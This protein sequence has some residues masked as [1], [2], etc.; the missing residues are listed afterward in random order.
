MYAQILH[1]QAKNRTPAN[2]VV[3]LEDFDFKE[4]ENI[5]PLTIVQNPNITLYC[6]DPQNQRAIFVETPSD[7]DLSQAPFYYLAQYEHAQR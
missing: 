2:T 5:D 6:I 1:I 7:I 4:G 3:K